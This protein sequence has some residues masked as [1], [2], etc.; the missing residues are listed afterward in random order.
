MSH[1]IASIVLQP[2][3]HEVNLT[4]STWLCIKNNE[5]VSPNGK[6]PFEIPEEDHQEVVTAFYFASKANTRTNLYEVLGDKYGRNEG[7]AGMS[8][9]SN[10]VK[11]LAKQRES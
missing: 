3:G 8:I 7:R 1:S 11:N 10:Y 2:T 9:V 5:P 4:G 6:R